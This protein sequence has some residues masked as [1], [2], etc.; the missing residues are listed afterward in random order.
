V[1]KRLDDQ[2][3]GAAGDICSRYFTMDGQVC[4]SDLNA[5]TIGLTLQALGRVE[6]AVAVVRGIHKAPG[7]LGALR[8][9]FLTDLIIDEATAATV[10][11]LHEGGPTT[12]D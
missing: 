9:G 11:R 4:D 1:E 3:R 5:R 7:V 2:R 12:H 6:H 8:G 10:L